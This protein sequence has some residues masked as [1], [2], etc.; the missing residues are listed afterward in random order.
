MVQRLRRLV[1]DAGVEG[2]Q[3]ARVIGRLENDVNEAA[4]VLIQEG[5]QEQ[6]QNNQDNLDLKLGV[7]RCVAILMVKGVLKGPNI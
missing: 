1:N 2:S 7:L 6:Q 3:I 4:A 5:L